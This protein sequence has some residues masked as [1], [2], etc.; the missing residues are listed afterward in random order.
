[1]EI[2]PVSNQNSPGQGPKKPETEQQVQPPAID[3]SDQV[4]ISLDARK[5]LAELADQK[6]KENGRQLDSLAE[7]EEE[8]GR[9][10]AIRDKI[11]SGYYDQPEVRDRIVDRLLDDLDQ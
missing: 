3:K 4:E 5:L 9:I 1:M 8:S 11:E 6:L 10:K 7:S 2:G